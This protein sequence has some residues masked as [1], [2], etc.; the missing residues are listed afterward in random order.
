MNGEIVKREWLC[1]SPSTKKLYCFVCKLFASDSE[2]IMLASVGYGDWKHAPCD[3]ARHESYN[4]HL[5]Y[6]STY[7]F[8][9]AKKGSICKDLEEQ[10]ESDRKYWCKVLARVLSVIKFLSSRGPA[11]RGSSERV[12]SPQNGN[13][14][15]ILELLAEYDTFFA[16]HIQKRVSKGKGHVSY[17]SSTVCEEFIDAIAT[18]VLNIIISQI[19]QAKY[20]SVSVDSTPDV[21]NVDQLTIIFRYVLPDGPVERFVKFMPTRGHA[22]HQLA[23]ILLWSL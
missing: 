23:D 5:S 19:K 4:K 6:L 8:R 16:E 21:A 14:L 11:F 9:R 12:G 3:L 1:Y 18:K 22:G 7:F 13:F 20:Y 10:K 17:F 15:G 2:K